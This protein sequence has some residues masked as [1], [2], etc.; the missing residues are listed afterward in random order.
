[1][2]TILSKTMMVLIAAYSVLILAYAAVE[3]AD[4]VKPAP[5][6]AAALKALMSGNSLAG[7]GKNVIPN[8]PYD[9]KAH[10]GADGVLTMRLKP[11]W[12]GMEDSGSWWVNDEGEL[13]RKF[14]QMAFGKEGCWLF[15]AEGD[16]YRFKPVS[17]VAVEGLGAV[18]PGNILKP[19]VK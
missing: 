4:E 3:A 13:C 18:L 8:K 6:D 11:A 14:K 10:Y 12:G 2:R 15:Y 5:L 1:M 16:F 17:G 7:N 9:W 19:P